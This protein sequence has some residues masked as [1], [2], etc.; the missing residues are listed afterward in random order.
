[1]STCAFNLPIFCTDAEDLLALFK[2]CIMVN[3]KKAAVEPNRF[4]TD[5][6]V[7]NYVWCRAA[8]HCELC[9]S[10]LTKDLITLT[11]TKLGEVAHI[12]PASPKGP[13]ADQGQTP[14]VSEALTND[15]SNLMLLCASCH[16]KIDKTPDNYPK[17]DL[18]V[19]HKAFVDSVLF[20]AQHNITHPSAGVIIIGRHFSTPVGI[21]PSEIQQALWRDRTRPVCEPLMIEGPELDRHGRDSRYYENFKE[22]IL[23]KLDRGL[24]PYRGELGDTPIIGVVGIA[25]IP[26]LI[27]F[28]KALG[29]R[30]RHK[31]YSSDRNSRLLWPD[32]KAE[33]PK[34]TFDCPDST[35]SAYAL[36]ISISGEVPER[37]VRS[38]LPDCTIA[39]FNAATPNYHVIQNEEAIIRFGIEIQTALS[40]LEAKS[41]K[42]IHVFAAIPAAMAIKLGTLLTTNHQHPYV[43]YDRDPPTNAFRPHLDINQ[44]GETE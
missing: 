43:I 37:D 8:G 35:N 36:V 18:S 16:T 21:N 10:D 5:P 12:I 13:R 14:E 2:G 30:I 27:M 22:R 32:L 7:K 6:K 41:S 1:M 39:R 26:S 34:F 28:G 38:A 33:A 31:I 19:I 9:S 44:S 11:E 24:T 15:S 17:D 23:R 42:P 29:D 40:Q 3:R 25:D 20:A 4:D